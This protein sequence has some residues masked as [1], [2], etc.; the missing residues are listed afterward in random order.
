MSY[1]ERALRQARKAK[2]PEEIQE[3][4]AE[5]RLPLLISHIPQCPFK[6]RG[7][8][9]AA[10][11]ISDATFLH[12]AALGWDAVGKF[13]ACR[14]SDGTGGNTLYDTHYDAVRMHPNE[15]DLYVYIRLRNEGMSVCDAEIF[16]K[17][18][19]QAYEAGF[20]MTDPD[21]RYNNRALIPRQDRSHQIR[22]ARGLGRH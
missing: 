17:V 7:H 16:L 22:I 3:A 13:I 8:T 6:G 10:R 21:N 19:R 20:R 14:M 2:T 18:A 5:I 9:D 4:F 11:R 12:R 15:S 1:A